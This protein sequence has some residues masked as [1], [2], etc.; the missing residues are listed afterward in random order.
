MAGSVIGLC[1]GTMYGTF[2]V[3][4]VR[5]VTFGQRIQL[6]AKTVAGSALS[7]GFFLAVGSAIRCESAANLHVCPKSIQTVQV[8]ALTAFSAAAQPERDQ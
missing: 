7:F 5:D 3:L 1:I 6:L 4:R 2:G 8:Q